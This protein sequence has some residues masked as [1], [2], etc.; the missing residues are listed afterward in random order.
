MELVSWHMCVQYWNVFWFFRTEM[1]AHINIVTAFCY[2]CSDILS[3]GLDS[4]LYSCEVHVFHSA[5]RGNVGSSESN[6]SC[7]RFSFVLVFILTAILLMWYKPRISVVKELY[8]HAVCLAGNVCRGIVT[9]L[10]LIVASPGRW[11]I[12]RATTQR[13]GGLLPSNNAWRC[14]SIGTKATCWHSAAFLVPQQNKQ[15]CRVL[16]RSKYTKL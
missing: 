6:L 3:S 13:S 4:H 1:Q 10:W 15:Y 12:E 14:L 9:G 16:K 8:G 7:Y 11:W 2:H 5:F